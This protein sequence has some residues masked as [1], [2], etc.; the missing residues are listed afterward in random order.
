MCASPLA[1]HVLDG[2]LFCF[3]NSADILLVIGQKHHAFFCQL[4]FLGNAE[5][6]KT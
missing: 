2:K 1:S 4:A 6:Y 3:G 5:P